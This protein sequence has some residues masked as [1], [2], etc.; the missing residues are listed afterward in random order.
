MVQAVVGAVQAAPVAQAEVLGAVLLAVAV[1]LL[2]AGVPPRAVELRVLGLLLVLVVL[3][4]LLL[5]LVG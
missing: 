5:R 4:G 3:A 2:A 1:L